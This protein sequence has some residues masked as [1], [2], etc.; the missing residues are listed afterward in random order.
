MNKYY[1][2]PELTK[3]EKEHSRLRAKLLFMTY[4][5]EGV[6]VEDIVTLLCEE[7]FRLLKDANQHRAAR[8]IDP[9]PVY[10]V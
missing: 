6:S 9:L 5:P 4:I 3:E 1:L 8:G 7:N 10:E 2:P